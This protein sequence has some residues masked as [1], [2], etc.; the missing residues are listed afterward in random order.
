MRY[1]SMAYRQGE[2]GGIGASAHQLPAG[3]IEQGLDGT[4]DD[5][6]ADLDENAAHDPRGKAGL[7][8]HIL[9]QDTAHLGGDGREG[10][11]Q[12]RN[13]RDYFSGYLLPSPRDFREKPLRN[14]R[15]VSQVLHALQHLDVMQQHGMDAP[16]EHLAQ[17]ARLALG[18]DQR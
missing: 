16:P 6:V 5:E 15:Q 10:V 14:R 13:G 4:V 7:Q 1:R 3:G 9:A 11:R 2:P 18:L 17:G 8:M 12:Q